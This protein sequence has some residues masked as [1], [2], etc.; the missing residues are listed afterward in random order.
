MLER[1]TISKD[2]QAEIYEGQTDRYGGS[3]VFKLTEGSVSESTRHLAFKAVRSR[4]QSPK[5]KHMRSDFFIGKHS[6]ALKDRFGS[7]REYL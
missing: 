2:V 1:E 3:L 5:V 6:N 7:L 4:V